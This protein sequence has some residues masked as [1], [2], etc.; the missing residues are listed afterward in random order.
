MNKQNDNED[1]DYLSVSEL[2]ILLKDEIKKTF[3]NKISIKGELSGYKKYNNTIYA[4]LKDDI[5][6]INIIKFKCT[7]QDNFK[8][9]DLVIITGNID[10]YVKNGLINFICTYIKHCGIGDIQLQLENLKQ[11]YKDLKYFDNKRSFP[12]NIKAIGIITAKNGAALQDILFVLNS[13]KF[14]GN[15]YIK[16]SPVQG[17]ECP[18]GIC[19]S[20]R[21]FNE[22]RDKQN[23]FVDL[24]MITR[25]GGSIDDLMGFSDPSVIEEIYKS[26]IFTMSAVGHEIDNMLSDYVADIRAPTPSIGAEII[27]KNCININEIIK[28]KRDKIGYIQ[29]NI[30][31]RLNIIKKN[32]CTIKKKMYID[33]YEKNI[34]RLDNLDKIF[35]NIIKDKFNLV[36]NNINTIKSNIDLIKHNEYNSILIRNNEVIKD[37]DEIHDGVYNIKINGKIKK[38]KISQIFN[39]F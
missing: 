5:S 33:I 16:N 26:K 21:Y 18:K 11:K 17:I 32:F 14:N 22:F 10:Y 25:G 24:I 8:S 27:C 36:K 9:G 28:N 6:S 4:N 13:N 19:S 37:I 38:I 30:T 20:I 3:Y 12:K 39:I 31:N 35:L 15:I 2:N 29:Q 1:K 23:N 7:T 34:S